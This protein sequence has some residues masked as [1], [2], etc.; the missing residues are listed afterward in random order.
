MDAA[1]NTSSH[2]LVLSVAVLIL[3]ATAALAYVEADNVYPIE[4]TADEASG[5]EEAVAE[6]RSS[7]RPGNVVRTSVY[8]VELNNGTS[9][10][11]TE[12]RP[13]PGSLCNTDNPKPS[14]KTRTEEGYTDVEAALSDFEFAISREGSVRRYIPENEKLC[15]TEITQ[16]SIQI[17]EC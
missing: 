1:S 8:V 9:F 2:V 11:F 13:G 16:K 4:T 5:Q 3:A 14:C 12:S 15:V 7:D 10:T 6:I 17:H